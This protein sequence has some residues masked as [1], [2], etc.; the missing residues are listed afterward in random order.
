MRFSSAGVSGWPFGLTHTG[1][2][3]PSSVV[4]VAKTPPL[5]RVVKSVA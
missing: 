1:W 5:A 4:A 2:P 3:D